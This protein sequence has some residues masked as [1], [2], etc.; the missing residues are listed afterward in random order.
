MLRSLVLTALLAFGITGWGL[1]PAAQ[2]PDTVQKIQQLLQAGDTATAQALLST[3]LQESPG[4]GGLYNLQGV[5]K[6]QQ[7]DFAVAETAN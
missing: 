6:V 4:N 3:A 5:L 2:S 1:P 7:G